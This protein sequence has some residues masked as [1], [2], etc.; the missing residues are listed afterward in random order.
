[1]NKETIRK[2]QEDSRRHDFWV[3]VFLACI[4]IPDCTRSQ[5]TSVADQALKDYDER[6]EQA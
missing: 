2:L 3:A 4:S 5:S 6:W 1:M